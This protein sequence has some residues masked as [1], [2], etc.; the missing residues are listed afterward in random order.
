[1]VKPKVSDDVRSAVL[2]FSY[3]RFST[4]EQALGDSH[5]RQL[6]AAEAWCKRHG[7]VLDNRLKADKGI[8][9]FRGAHRTK[10][11]LGRFLQVVEEGKVPSGSVLLIENLDRLGREAPSTTLRQIIFKLWDCGVVI[12]C[13]SPEEEYGPGCDTTP[14]FLALLIYLQRAHDESEQKS[15]RITSAREAERKEA[16]EKGRVLTRQ[17]PAWLNVTDEGEFAEIPEAVETVRRIFDLRLNGVGP[18]TIE[19]MLNEQA[20]WS[21]PPRKK[22]DR[23][24]GKPGNGWRA[25]YIKK[26][27]ANRAVLGEFQPYTGRLGERKPV[28]DPIPNY[29]PRVVDP[30][31]FHAVQDAMK[32]TAGKGGRT[33]KV[34]NL[35]RHIVKCGYCDQPMALIDKGKSPKGGKYLVCDNGRRGVRCERRPVR[36]D[37]VEQTVLANC[38]RLRPEEV[39]LDPDEQ[40]KIARSVRQRIAGAEGE[41]TD[42]AEQVENL[43][44]QMAR[45]K[46]AK[47][48]DRLEARIKTL[49]DKT[50]ELK[51]Q[52]ARDEA[53]LR[54]VESSRRSFD[55]WKR[56]LKTIQ[57][58]AA[59]DDAVDLRLRLAAHLRDL[60]E[61]IDVFAAGSPTDEEAEELADHLEAAVSESNPDWKPDAAFRAFQRHLTERR[62]TKEGRFFRVTFKTGATVK[63]VPPGSL[64]CGLELA[65]TDEGIGWRF[66]NPD[67][68][69]LWGEFRGRNGKRG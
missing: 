52:K 68:D 46:D 69:R 51:T 5:R 16:R 1:M 62:K 33:G 2:V 10:G 24:A 42:A 43:M 50:F 41:L 49:D 34:K 40:E 35:L 63:M 39:L 61:R 59:K 57:E 56:D 37:E 13:L 32:E 18:R 58:Q 67:L 26:I 44:D 66:A 64:A 11:A 28:G 15:H 12:Q 47:M 30:P 25:S 65:R 7:H 4:P 53:E 54:R 17:I 9:G 14:K 31:V 29:F 45:T 55:A 23:E 21:P 27:L 48:R 6:A 20:A 36:Y 8:S 19:R 3:I 60:I 22:K 38:H